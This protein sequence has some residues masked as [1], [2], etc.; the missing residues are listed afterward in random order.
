MLGFRAAFARAA[1]HALTYTETPLS[2]R[3]H[4][5]A[6]LLS[7]TRK[8]VTAR[9]LTFFPHALARPPTRQPAALASSCLAP[10][11]VR[12]L[13]TPRRCGLAGSHLGSLAMSLTCGPIPLSSRFLDAEL[14]SLLSHLDR[15][16][17]GH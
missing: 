6:H 1:Q 16:R 10:P 13:A 17:S 11:T 2:N 15:T 12:Q 5:P 4:A 14:Y 8:L 3:Q 9:Q 7:L